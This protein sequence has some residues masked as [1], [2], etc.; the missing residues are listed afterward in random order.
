MGHML[1]KLA[2]GTFS[3]AYAGEIPWHG[4]G[5]EVEHDLTPKEMQEAANLDWGVTKR[6]N[7]YTF[8]GEKIYTGQQSLIRA[9]D[10]RYLT[11]VSPGWEPVQNDT[12]F[13]FFD[14]FIRSGDMTMNTAGS[15]DSGE[16]LLVWAL[17]K[18]NDGFT[19]FGG[20]TVESYLLFTNPH[21]YGRSVDIRFTPIRTVCWNTVSLALARRGDLMVRLNHRHKFDE[22]FVKDTLGVATEKMQTY[23]EVAE[24]LGKKR[25]KKNK[26]D[27]AEYLMKVF[28]S[29]STKEDALKKL[30]RPAKIAFD[31]VET[32]PGAD[33]APGTF[34]NA[35]NAVTFTTDHLLG[36]ND[37]TRMASAWYGTNRKRKTDALKLAVE[38]A[39]AA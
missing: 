38:Y 36:H 2:D 6:K 16:G 3:M 13:E 11:T 15:I 19:L 32:Q 8:N 37:N 31:I 23:K 10:G 7:F 28:P 35:F 1:E 39:E 21:I 34:W 22:E 30:S 24:L 9:T 33:Y 26:S 20:D 18:V 27:L 5:T 12:A 17:A 25:Y 4:L 29:T 14:D